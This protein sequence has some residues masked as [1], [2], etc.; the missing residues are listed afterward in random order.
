M[1]WLLIPIPFRV[2]AEVCRELMQYS[3]SKV[4]DGIKESE[5]HLHCVIGTF[6]FL[7]NFLDD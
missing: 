2:T 4:D 1:F 3:Q 7:L 5:T 6:E